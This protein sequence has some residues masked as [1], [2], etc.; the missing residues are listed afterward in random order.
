MSARPG[1]YGGQP[2]MVVPTVI[3]C[4]QENCAHA[5]AILAVHRW[6]LLG[7]L[8]LALQ[9]KA[10]VEMARSHTFTERVGEVRSA[11]E[12]CG[13]EGMGRTP[14]QYP[15]SAVG[16]RT[17]KESQTQCPWKWRTMSVMAML[18]QLTEMPAGSLYKVVG[19]TQADIG[20]QRDAHDPFEWRGITREGHG[21][22]RLARVAAGEQKVSPD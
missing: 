8:L 16:T 4:R 12:D 1:L 7:V 19:P 22:R 10:Q 20:F 9:N 6:T 3:N 5:F 17:E 18:P 21:L 2:V 13:N 15:P 11:K 14:R